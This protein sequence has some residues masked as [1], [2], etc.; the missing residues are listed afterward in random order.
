MLNGLIALLATAVV[1]GACGGAGSNGSNA[2]RSGPAA[3][4]APNA[5][6]TEPPKQYDYGPKGTPEA[7]SSD[8]Y[9]GY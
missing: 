9:Y 2:P 1:I 6:G 8:G 7:S 5:G 4:A 3:T